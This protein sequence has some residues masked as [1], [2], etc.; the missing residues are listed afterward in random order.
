MRLSYRGIRTERIGGYFIYDGD[1]SFCT[2]STTLIAGVN[3]R[4]NVIASQNSLELLSK[5]NIDHRLINEGAIWISASGNMKF[6]AFAI[7]SA[8]KKGNFLKKL[9][10]FLIEVFPIHYLSRFIYRQIAKRRR[11][12]VWGA[13]SCSLEPSLSTENSRR[14]VEEIATRLYV[15][16]Q[17]GLPGVLLA[18][19]C[20]PINKNILYGWGW[21]MFS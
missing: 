6:G 10:G 11:L 4:F 3:P 7:S 19:R 5:Y 1:C 12:I 15:L 21:Q 20:P 18:L 2:R 9:L 8:L 16:L 17:F 13:S 14:S